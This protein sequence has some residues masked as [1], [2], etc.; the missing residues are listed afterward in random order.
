[1]KIR[2]IFMNPRKMIYHPS[3]FWKNKN[4]LVGVC[5][6]IAAFKIAHLVSYLVKSGANV[7]VVMT[8]NAQHFIGK[9]TFEALTGKRVYDSLFNVPGEIPHIELARKND[10]ILVAP[11]TA[12]IIAKIACGIGDDLLSTL[13]MVEPQKLFIVPAMNHKMW[14][15]PAVQENLNKLRTRNIKILSPER[16]KLACGEEGEGR[17]PEIENIIEEMFY[18]IYDDKFL[19]GKKVL[20]TAGAT[21]EWLDP[22]RYISNPSSGIMGYSLAAQAKALGAEVILISGKTHPRV[23]SGVESE[24]IDTALQ[25]AQKTEEL[26]PNCDILL[27]SAA[28]SDFRPEVQKSSKIKKHQQ[29]LLELRLIPT[30]DILSAVSKLKKPKQIVVGFCAETENP[31]EEARR[32]LKTKN[33]D[34]IIANLIE[35]DKSGFEVLTNKAWIIDYRGKE[36]EFPLLDKRDLAEKIFWHLK[37]IFQ[38]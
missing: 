16:G 10:L 22:V 37:E 6:G 8:N 20:V 2:L 5:G 1:M 14:R 7:Q 32:K 36:I 28:V 19:S 21:R 4:I 34:L 30:I 29:E 11:A 24:E 23:P 13:C 38:Q 26:F 31:L 33:L 9:S 27:M 3:N 25:L 35:K 12:N 17:L 15:N 18:F